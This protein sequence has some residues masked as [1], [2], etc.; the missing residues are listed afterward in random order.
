MKD[1]RTPQMRRA[2]A[3]R[4]D[5]ERERALWDTERAAAGEAAKAAVERAR[6]EEQL[7]AA[8]QRWVTDAKASE[9]AS[10][11]ASAAALATERLRQEEWLKSQTV[12]Q[13]R[14]DRG[15]AREA[16]MAASGAEPRDFVFATT[17]DSDR[18]SRH[19]PHPG[20]ARQREGSAYH[21]RGG[22]SPDRGGDAYYR[23]SRDHRDPRDH[24]SHD[25][26]D[27]HHHRR[28]RGYEGDPNEQQSSSSNRSKS[29]NSNSNIS[30]R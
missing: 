4:A 21:R 12:K 10:A 5:L 1:A 8:K 9:L 25:Y 13:N 29:S 16:L 6:L 24:Y 19:R 28:S 11:A 22:E 23:A 17:G 18:H 26:D 7:V 27:G 14:F 30:I 15:F 20:P 3:D 2:A